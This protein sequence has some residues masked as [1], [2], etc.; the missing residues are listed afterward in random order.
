[1]SVSYAVYGTF[2]GYARFR[3]DGLFYGSQKVSSAGCYYTV[4]NVEALA[5]GMHTLAVELLENTGKIVASG[6][7]PFVIPSNLDDLFANWRVLG[8]ARENIPLD[9]TFTVKFSLP[10]DEKTATEES[11]Q[12]YRYDTAQPV[13]VIIQRVDDFTFQMRPQEALKPAT[14]YWVVVRP[15]VRSR[16]GLNLKEG[17]VAHFV[18][19]QSS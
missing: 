13:A 18:T 12:L 9:H 11:L 19:V 8:S 7:A 10:I 17:V 5:K 16:T 6:Q 14:R 2:S 4:L 3:V 15:S 1:M